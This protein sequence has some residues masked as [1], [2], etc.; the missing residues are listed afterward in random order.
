MKRKNKILLLGI[1]GSLSI[2]ALGGVLVSCSK[3]DANKLDA[4]K[5]NVINAN[6]VKKELSFVSDMLSDEFI[7]SMPSEINKQN[8]DDWFKK[9]GSDI[10]YDSGSEENPVTTELHTSTGTDSLISNE[11][12]ANSTIKLDSELAN[13]TRKFVVTI[14]SEDGLSKDELNFVRQFTE[15]AKPLAK[16]FSEDSPLFFKDNIATINGKL[17]SSAFNGDLVND[18]NNK[19]KVYK[20][21]NDLYKSDDFTK[22]NFSFLYN[23]EV[24][25]DIKDLILSL[26]KENTSASDDSITLNM[27]LNNKSVSFNLSRS[28]RE[29]YAK[30]RNLFTDDFIK[31]NSDNLDFVNKSDSK[32]TGESK[33]EKL[34]ITYN[35]IVN[36]RDYLFDEFFP[37]A[38]PTTLS[39]DMLNKFK[40]FFNSLSSSNVSSSIIANPLNSNITDSD[41][42]VTASKVSNEN[43]SKDY[44]LVLKG[45][46]YTLNLNV[47]T[48]ADTKALTLQNYVNVQ[49]ED[50]LNFYYDESNNTYVTDETALV[51]NSENIQ[52]YIASYRADDKNG[53]L[54]NVLAGDLRFNDAKYPEAAKLAF[55]TLEAPEEGYE[56]LQDLKSITQPDDET[57]KTSL[58][59]NPITL[60]LSPVST[61]NSEGQTVTSEKPSYKMNLLLTQANMLKLIKAVPVN[62]SEV[63]ERQ[64]AAT[65]NEFTNTL[66]YSSTINQSFGSDSELAKL[67]KKEDKTD[68][69]NYLISN[70]LKKNHSLTAEMLEGIEVTTSSPEV[71][72]STNELTVTLSAT[73]NSAT[74]G[75]YAI[76]FV[77]KSEL[78]KI[79]NHYKDDIAKEIQMRADELT[80]VIDLKKADTTADITLTQAQWEALETNLNTRV[81]SVMNKYNDLADALTNQMNSSEATHTSIITSLTDSYKA[82]FKE[83][84]NQFINNNLKS[85]SQLIKDLITAATTK[86]EP[87]TTKEEPATTTQDTTKLVT[88]VN[89]IIAEWKKSVS[90]DLFLVDNRNNETIINADGVAADSYSN[91]KGRTLDLLKELYTLRE[92]PANASV[93]FNDAFM[94][95]RNNFNK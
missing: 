49:R 12:P 89:N 52:K 42:T 47:K 10:S 61:T 34:E 11:I 17:V 18:L 23:S 9:L 48:Q 22:N 38:E 78:S 40:D 68:L 93:E 71:S 83:W 8:L 29:D 57:A 62:L 56:L 35:N 39:N 3:K 6:L 25:N 44:N 51:L 15:E 70:V 94:D 36:N 91:A 19:E 2:A 92:W 13:G 82:I 81:S 1:S 60:T 20:A 87:A 7:N 50:N 26:G 64:Q 72:N 53:F 55:N 21:L 85:D 65:E 95:A 37:V 86:E 69:V 88:Y 28:D 41:L 32:V 76:Q 45:T 58:F 73:N 80:K 31:N 30:I 24:N 63:T 5:L 90:G 43:Q 67:V 79:V 84:S 77:L 16:L 14:S 27:K 74:D 54:S 4:T 33:E 75:K 66:V 59:T 46:D